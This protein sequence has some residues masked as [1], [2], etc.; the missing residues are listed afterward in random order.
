MKCGHLH[1]K[2]TEAIPWYILLI[3]LMGPYKIIRESHDHPIILKAITIID[4]STGWFEIV[5]Y[6]DKQAA[7]IS[8]LLY[9]K[10]LCKC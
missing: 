10:W 7:T 1:A 3:D 9:Q 2:E 6:N 8:T 5:Q 4:P